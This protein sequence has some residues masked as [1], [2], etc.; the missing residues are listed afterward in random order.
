MLYMLIIIIGGAIVDLI[1]ELT[2]MEVCQE[3]GSVTQHGIHPI[4][5]KEDNELLVVT[6]LIQLVCLS[7]P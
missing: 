6:L 5:Y 2:D 7:L 3:K 1:M 4:I